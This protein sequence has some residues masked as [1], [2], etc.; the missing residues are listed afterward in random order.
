MLV[1]NGGGQKTWVLRGASKM[2]SRVYTLVLSLRTIPFHTCTI[3][4]FLIYSSVGLLKT[5][6]SK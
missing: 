6:T 5:N 3:D 4:F 2:A 1:V